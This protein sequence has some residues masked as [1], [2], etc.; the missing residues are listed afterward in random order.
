MKG[1]SSDPEAEVQSDNVHY[2]HSTEYQPIKKKK[3]K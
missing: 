3:I 2:N 1:P